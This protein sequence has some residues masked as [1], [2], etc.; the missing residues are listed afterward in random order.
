MSANSSKM[1]VDHISNLSASKKPIEFLS[2]PLFDI[3]SSSEVLVRDDPLQS[4][5]HL[6]I[7]HLKVRGNEY[8]HELSAMI[9]NRPLNRPSPLL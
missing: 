3:R 7:K 6:R 8:S 4:R 1:L 2:I 5:R 9:K